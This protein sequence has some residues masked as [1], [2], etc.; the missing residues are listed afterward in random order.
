MKNFETYTIENCSNL[1][2]PTI[3]FFL[4]NNG[5]SE[6]YIKHLR[7]TPNAI[8]LNDS[9]STIN[10]QIKVGDKVSISNNPYSASNIQPCEG[11]LDILF[12]DEDFL[13]VNKPH[14]LSCMPTHSHYS[15]NLG[16][17]IVNYMQTKQ[18]DFV[19]R[20]VN[21]LDKD[22][23]GIVV[24]AKNVIARNN[25]SSINKVYHALCKNTFDSL[26][27]FTINKPIH[28]VNTNG[29]NQM[30]RIISNEGKQSITNVLPLANFDNYSLIQATLETGRTHQIRVHLSSINH[31]LIGDAIYNSDFEG[32]S[33][34]SYLILK[35]ITFVH[36][37]THKTISL[38]VPYPSIWNDKINIQ[39]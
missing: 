7:N 22:T 21:R 3:Y 39:Q 27:P 18:P 24:V 26:L 20:I 19:L 31:P 34:N 35:K 12:E 9:P 30:K 13:I 5:F 6:H 28:T 10:A 23:A 17:Q 33:T 14:T 2:K 15:N 37:R 16:G 11:N 38:E 29:I 25:I 4:K 36:F 8:L 1:K 32:Q